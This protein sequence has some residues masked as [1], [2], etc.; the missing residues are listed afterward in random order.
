[1]IGLHHRIKTHR[2]WQVAQPYPGIYLWRD[3]HGATYLVDHTGTRRPPT[4]TQPGRRS[5]AKTHRWKHAST[6]SYSPADHSR[7]H[8]SSTNSASAF[9]AISAKVR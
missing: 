9:G 7:G 2:R 6:T 1:M 4:P 8:P 3:P 5:P